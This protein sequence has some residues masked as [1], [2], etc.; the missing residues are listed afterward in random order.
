MNIYIYIY[1]YIYIF[2]YE[3]DNVCTY[4]YEWD[5]VYGCIVMCVFLWTIDITYIIHTVNRHIIVMCLLY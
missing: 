1:I 5:N 2:M 4:V 3:W